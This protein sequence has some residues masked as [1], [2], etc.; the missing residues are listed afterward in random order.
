M[1]DDERAI[2]IEGLL[3]ERSEATARR[4]RLVE[5]VSELSAR[6]P[7]IR[8]AFGNPFF[9]SH[10]DH[11]DESPANDTGASSHDVFMPTLLALM[12]I[13][14]VLAEINRQLADV[15]VSSGTE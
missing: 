4:A 5:E 13:E 14:R 6:L 10:P 15:G 8:A 11:A 3:K 9:Y 7:E 1:S 2:T 12:D